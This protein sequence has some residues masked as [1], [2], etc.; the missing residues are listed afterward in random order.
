MGNLDA[1]GTAVRGENNK[2]ISPWAVG[3][4]YS[5]MRTKQ[6]GK[7]CSRQQHNYYKAVQALDLSESNFLKC[8]LCLD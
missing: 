5:A 6:M 8:F 2:I 1:T 7:S 3:R 4:D